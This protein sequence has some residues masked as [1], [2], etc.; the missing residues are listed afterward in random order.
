MSPAVVILPS[1]GY[2]VEIGP[3]GRPVLSVDEDEDYSPNLKELAPPRAEI[4][5]T[6]LAVTNAEAEPSDEELIK[7]V[8]TAGCQVSKK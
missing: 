7:I 2:E 3:D 8:E 5:P 1:N 4:I 6:Q